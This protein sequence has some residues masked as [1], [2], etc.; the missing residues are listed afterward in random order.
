[1]RSVFTTD[2]SYSKELHVLERKARIE[3]VATGRESC[4]KKLVNHKLPQMA[5]LQA[6]NIIDGLVE[7]QLLS[8]LL[9]VEIF[10]VQ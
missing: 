6:L 7:M 8:F 2:L 3:K 4:I 1:V 9:Q 5:V 10:S